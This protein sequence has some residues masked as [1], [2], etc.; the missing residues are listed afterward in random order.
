MHVEVSEDG[1]G[2]YLL[3]VHGFCASRAQ[4]RPN[5]E[6]LKRV[7][8]PVVVEMLG[9][10][11]SPSPTDPAE[12][13]VE[14]YFERFEAL[15]A[16]LG[17]DRWLLCGQSFGAGLTLGYSLAFPERVIGQAFTN[18]NSALAPPPDPPI[19]A[20]QRIGR[21]NSFERKGRPALEAM[22]YYPKRTDRWPKAVVD[23]V[24]ADGELLSVPAIAETMRTTIPD[25]NVS[26]RLVE[27]SVPTLLVNG[28]WEKGFQRQRDTAARTIPGLKVVDLEGG[29]PV[30]L[31]NPAGFNEAA[32][33]FLGGL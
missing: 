32:C 24:M 31:D 14:A 30:N 25:L 6:A 7:S 21:A 22:P 28:L 1:T 18:S 11:R 15:R 27:I 13:R 4:W 19:S 10:G 26:A 29:H 17:A 20:E 23:E 12:Y 2:P 33:D 9:H 5:L 8:R 3:L 16:R